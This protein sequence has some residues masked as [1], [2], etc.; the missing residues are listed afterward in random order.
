MLK[1]RTICVHSWVSS[2]NQRRK[3]L[4]NLA[5]S[6]R[7]PPRLS[8]EQ[9]VSLVVSGD[10]IINR[11]RSS[12]KKKA[13]LRTRHY[14]H[15]TYNHTAARWHRWRS[16]QGRFSPT[17]ALRSFGIRVKVDGAPGA[18]NILTVMLVR[19]AASA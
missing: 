14:L 6:F 12:T 19:G 3:R 11:K 5:V 16:V 7:N 15:P 2:D 4:T 13:I 8:A 18:N 1:M 9:C 10:I 17:Y